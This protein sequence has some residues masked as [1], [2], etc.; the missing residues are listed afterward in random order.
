GRKR[1]RSTVSHT[2]RYAPQQPSTRCIPDTELNFCVSSDQPPAISR[3]T[4]FIE[5]RIAKQIREFSNQPSRL[6]VEEHKS[7]FLAENH[8]RKRR[9]STVSHTVR[10]APQQPSTRCIPDT[11]LNFCV[12]SDQPPAISRETQFIEARIA[13]QIREFSNQPSR[14]CV[15]EHKSHFLAEN[16]V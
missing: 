13:K 3:E 8:G 7:H 4:Q 9:R 12:S 14:L 1:R 5:A 6:C 15:E 11:E 16:H 2:V 10:Y